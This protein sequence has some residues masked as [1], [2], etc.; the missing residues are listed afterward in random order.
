M[1]FQRTAHRARLRLAVD[2][3]S[4]AEGAENEM[5]EQRIRLVRDMLQFA[6]ADPE[7]KEQKSNGHR[8]YQS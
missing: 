3:D 2:K 4:Q 1:I 5:I 7:G 8:V 6:T